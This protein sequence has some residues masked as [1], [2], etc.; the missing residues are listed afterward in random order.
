MTTHDE[1]AYSVA[2]DSI[3]QIRAG[4]APW[5]NLFST[6]SR[7]TSCRD[8]PVPDFVLRDDGN[9]LTVAAEFKP[10]G[11][12]KREYLTGLGQAIAYTRDFD[13]GLLIVPHIADDGY[14]IASHIKDILSLNE[15]NAA[16]VGLVEYDPSKIGPS[17]AAASISKFF[18]TRVGNPPHR[19]HV[20]ESF[21][22]KWRE[23]SPEE[24][25]L[26]LGYLYEEKMRSSGASQSLRDRGF[27]RLWTDIQAGKVH[28]WAGG[29]RHASPSTEEGVRKNYR[30]FMNHVGWM[31]S[32][33][34][35]TEDGLAA[36]HVANIYG[37]ASRL[38]LNSIARSLLLAGKH[39]ILIN[40]I[41]QFQDNYLSGNGP[42]PDE[43]H[44][45]GLIENDLE[46]RGLLKR[47]V[48]RH[49][50]AVQNSGRQF[51]KAEKQLWKNT[52]L[53]IPRSA[54]RV[55]HQGRG[56]VF[57]WARITELVRSQ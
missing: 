36:W 52:G 53:I 19:A 4:A 26:Y 35:L 45:L 37:F 3:S 32:D 48:G 6:N 54:S 47:N 50:A 18:G 57:D 46:K 14:Q 23:M 16:P 5:V 40:A 13:Y 20:G 8:W 1:L 30:N 27:G 11:Q 17:F 22:A 29:V 43:Q 2:V 51:L 24:M 55:Y 42:F 44:W 12:S 9:D 33:G 56:F 21:Y 10:P 49:A 15:F 25:A 28:H 38:F 39:L 34:A 41:N 31:E 7:V